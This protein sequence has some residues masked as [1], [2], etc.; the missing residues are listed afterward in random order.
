L[1]G[2]SEPST[3]CQNIQPVFDG[4]R[5]KMLSNFIF[6]RISRQNAINPVKVFFEICV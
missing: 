6:D 3:A 5:K 4:Y 1:I 2:L